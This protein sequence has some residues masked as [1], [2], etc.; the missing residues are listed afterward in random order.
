MSGWLLASTLIMFVAPVLDRIAGQRLS[1]RMA[2]V[3]DVLIAV[4]V[5]AHIIPECVHGLGWV[6]ILICLLGIVVPTA[7]EKLF[8]RC[9]PQ[10]HIASRVLVVAG[11]IIHNYMD[12]AMIVSVLHAPMG[13]DAHASIFLVLH[14]LPVA[15]AVWRNSS[16]KL[17]WGILVLLALSNLCGYLVQFNFITAIPMAWHYGLL[18]FMAG[19]FLHLSGHR[20]HH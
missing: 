15:L 4:L 17:A 8:S 19:A 13:M 11:L 9:V 7:I 18:A 3:F 10:V 14:K 20:L 2:V 5:I 6:A 1:A 16:N 12:G